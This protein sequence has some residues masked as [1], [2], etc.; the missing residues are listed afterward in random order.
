MFRCQNEIHA[1]IGEKLRPGGLGLAS[2]LTFDTTSYTKSA[3]TARPPGRLFLGLRAKCTTQPQPFF[4]RFLHKIALV[5]LPVYH[6]PAPSSP[7]G[8]SCRLANYVMSRCMLMRQSRLT[9]HGKQNGS[10][11]SI[12]PTMDLPAGQVGVLMQNSGQ[13]SVA[14]AR[15]TKNV[16]RMDRDIT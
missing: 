4:H 7:F 8:E 11:I 16:M 3:A 12:S 14:S 13:P 9:K 5:G 15:G 10:S 6:L 2:V 1:G